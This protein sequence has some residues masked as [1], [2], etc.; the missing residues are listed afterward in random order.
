MKHYLIGKLITIISMEDEPHYTGRTG[1]V[2]SVDS[3]GQLHGTWGGLAVN[4][5]VD[6][7]VVIQDASY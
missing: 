1:I 4:P 5:L 6:K 3:Y 2:Q 7:Y